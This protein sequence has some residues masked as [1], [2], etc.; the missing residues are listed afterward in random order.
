VCRR[1]LRLVVRITSALFRGDRRGEIFAVPT[2][3]SL[4]A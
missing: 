3:Y 1:V 4:Q 2:I